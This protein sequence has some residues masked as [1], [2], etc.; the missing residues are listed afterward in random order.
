MYARESVERRSRETRETI[1]AA[2]EEKRETARIARPNEIRVVPL[3]SRAF[4]HARGHLRVSDVLLDGPRKKRD[5][6]K[7]TSTLQLC[8]NLDMRESNE[9]VWSNKALR[10]L[11]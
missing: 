6:S 5:C 11:L 3:P 4:S 8:A 1:A 10:D 7:S 2:R 9:I